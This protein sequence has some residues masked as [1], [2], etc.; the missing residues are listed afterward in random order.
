MSCVLLSLTPRGQGVTEFV[1]NH[2]KKNQQ[3]EHDAVDRGRA[4]A[5][6]IEDEAKPGKQ[7]K[8]CSVDLD[9]YARDTREVKRPPH[10]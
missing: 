1:E 2:A 9:V 8:E 6:P 5:L 4:S 10:D 7:Q 3:D